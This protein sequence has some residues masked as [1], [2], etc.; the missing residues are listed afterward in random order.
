MNLNKN[1][2]AVTFFVSLELKKKIAAI[3]DSGYNI[4]AL[5]RELIENFYD[6]KV[7]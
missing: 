1:K 5:L 6:E 4:S 7:K 3:R 2:K